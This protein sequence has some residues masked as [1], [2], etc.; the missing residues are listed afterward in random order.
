MNKIIN[1]IKESYTE[2]TDNVTW[3]SFK[4]AQD[5][6]VLVLVASVVFALVI[7]AVD[8]GFNE[9]LTAFYTAY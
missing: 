1:F 5:S 8:F 4:E 7:G 3:L 2:M 6:S 9:I